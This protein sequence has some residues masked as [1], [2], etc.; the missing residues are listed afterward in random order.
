MMDVLGKQEGPGQIDRNGTDC[1]HE[2]WPTPKRQTPTSVYLV[3]TNVICGEIQDSSGLNLQQ[4]E[5]DTLERLEARAD[6]I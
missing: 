1:P 4:T 6:V 3:R 2:F 5:E